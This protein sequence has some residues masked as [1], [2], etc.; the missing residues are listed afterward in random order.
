MI[1]VSTIAEKYN[2]HK[3][4]SPPQAQVGGCVNNWR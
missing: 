3:R 1:D 4:Q 2:A